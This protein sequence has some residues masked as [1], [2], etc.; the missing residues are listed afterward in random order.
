MNKSIKL[1]VNYILGPLLFVLLM[2]LLYRQ[3][4]RQP[5]LES[6]WQE[7]RESWKNP[8]L[9]LAVLMLF[10]NWGIEALKWKQLLSPLQTISLLHSL[11]SVFAGC[12]I[13]MFTPNRTGEFGGRILFVKPENRI[14]A[15]SAT[16]VGSISQLSVTLIIGSLSLAFLFNETAT[17]KLQKELPWVFNQSVLLVSVVAGALLL[18]FY[19]RLNFLISLLGRTDLSGKILSYVAFVKLFNR[20]T[21]LRILFY[22]LLRYMVFIL[23]YILLL[24][25][26]DVQIS[27]LLGFELLAVFYLL[28]AILPTIGFTEL[29]VRATASVMILGIFSDNTIGIQAAALG[30]WI[31]NL[32]IPSVIGGFFLIGNKIYQDI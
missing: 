6:R 32:V 10:V 16:F 17:Y 21:L 29:P 13:T 4:I 27:G 12:S 9:W 23:Q 14:K 3:I 19:F 25:V 7:I 24:R 2:L 8:L 5:D 15:I 22:S 11:K 18:L 20:K 28:M 26:L 1:T 31:I 30:I